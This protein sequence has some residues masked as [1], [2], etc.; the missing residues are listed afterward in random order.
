M[1]IDCN[2]T[3]MNSRPSCASV[4]TFSVSFFEYC[5]LCILRIWSQGHSSLE[6][7]VLYWCNVFYVR[8]DWFRYRLEIEFGVCVIYL[9]LNWL[10]RHPIAFAP[11][12]CPLIRPSKTESS[13]PSPLAWVKNELT[14]AE[15][16]H[17]LKPAWRRFKRHR[18]LCSHCAVFSPPLWYMQLVI[19]ECY[20]LFELKL[21]VRGS[22]SSVRLVKMIN[23]VPKSQFAG[24]FESFLF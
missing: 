2:T 14:L 17:I 4:Y 6:C 1:F 19:P 5:N 23:D 24:H 8:L 21:E 9:H 11:W 22:R 13:D 12:H 10:D 7:G 15:W 18:R 16:S 20:E 3:D